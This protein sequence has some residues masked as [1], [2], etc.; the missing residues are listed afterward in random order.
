MSEEILVKSGRGRPKGQK[1]GGLNKSEEIRNYFSQNPVAKTRDCIEGLG[2]KGIVVT[3]ALVTAVKNRIDGKGKGKKKEV[4]LVE[5]QRVKSFIDKSGLEES[6]A[7]NILLDFAE[8]VVGCGGIDRF[9]E[10]L[11]QYEN[12]T[13]HSIA[14]IDVEDSVEDSVEDTDDSEDEDVLESEYEDV[15][16]SEYE[17]VNDEDN[18]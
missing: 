8:L 16:E 12:F 3:A 7:S 11:A 2:K 4:T 18:E 17:D 5:A 1:D 13:G 14:T 9:K 6:V 15:L 10:I